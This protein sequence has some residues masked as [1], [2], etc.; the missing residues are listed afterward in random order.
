[1]N[2]SVGKKPENPVAQ[3]PGYKFACDNCDFNT[4][5]N[6][7]WLKHLLTAKHRRAVGEISKK[8]EMNRK[9]TRVKKK[10]FC[11]FCNR[12]F[13]SPS[14]RWKHEKKC[15]RNP[16]VLQQKLEEAK[17]EIEFFKKEKEEQN[18]KIHMLE[19]ENLKDK[20]EF[21]TESLKREEESHQKTRELKLGSGQTQNIN[22][23]NNNYINIQLYL[24]E[25]CKNAMPIM[26][27]IKDLQFK[28]L[29]INSERPASTIESLGKCITDK[30]E[31][32]DVTERPMHCSDVK[33][34][35][36]HV[37]DASGWAKDVDNKKIDKA[38]GWA[39][40]RHQGAWHSYAK[41]EGIDKSKVKDTDY[42]NMNVAMAHFSDD[43]K[44]AKGKIKRVIASTTDFKNVKSLN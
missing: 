26:D 30:L 12:F 3:K 43:P 44:K 14:G 19:K 35:V 11:K 29:D 25:K 7:D 31:D 13:K 23:Q 20:V 8:P 24:D 27:F 4:S 33:R 36:F 10:Q 22:T 5:H 18:K 16:M 17:K 39:N 28:L 1:M 6:N 37:K 2:G 34:L 21:L 41:K 32:M 38:I 15:L 40:M 9:K 42:H